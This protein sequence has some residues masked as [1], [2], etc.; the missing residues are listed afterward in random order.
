MPNRR[1]FLRHAAGASAGVFCA[2]CGLRRAGAQG[3][4]A[5]G[6]AGKRR[7]VTVGG[8]RIKTIDVHCH[9]TV[10]DVL[11]LVKGTAMEKALRQQ[12][13]GSLGFPVGPERVAHMDG[14]GID[15]QAMSINAYWYGAD[16]DLA[17]GS[18]ICRTR[19]S[20]RCAPPFRVGSPRSPRSH[21][22]FPRS[23]PSS[24]SAA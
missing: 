9:C 17:P 22:S 13:T 6:A 21:C 5:A 16:R 15:V 12:L 19:S 2:A 20:P 4:G 14:D 8:R 23:R 3:A 1:D 7:E 18:L 24:W 11:D 10:P